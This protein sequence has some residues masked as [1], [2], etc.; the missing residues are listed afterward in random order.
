M[1]AISAAV[2]ELKS[3]FLEANKGNATLLRAIRAAHK[4]S[5]SLGDQK[6]GTVILA[7]RYLV[8]RARS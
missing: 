5:T 2:L 7:T 8:L 1:G 4:R 6:H 3:T